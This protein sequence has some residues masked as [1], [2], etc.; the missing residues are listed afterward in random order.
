M[1]WPCVF[2]SFLSISKNRFINA[3]DFLKWKKSCPVIDASAWFLTPLYSMY[4]KWCWNEDLKNSHIFPPP[5]ALPS[6]FIFKLFHPYH[7][8]LFRISN[9]TSFYFSMIFF[10]TVLVVCMGVS[11]CTLSNFWFYSLSTYIIISSDAIE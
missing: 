1:Q 4:V 10:G 5:R 11:V 6:F 9:H 3:S 8:T 7:N 2:L